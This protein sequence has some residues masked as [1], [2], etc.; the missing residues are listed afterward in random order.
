MTHTIRNRD[1]STPV[2]AEQLKGIKFPHVKTQ[3]EI[4]ELE[5]LNIQKGIDW[6]HRQKGKEYL[7]SAFLCK[8]HKKLFGDVWKWAGTYRKVDVNLS[9]I[10]P[11]Q[12]PMDLEEFFRDMQAWMD[13]G[14]K[15]IKWDEFFAEF[16]HR[17]VSIHPFPNGNGRT[18]RLMTEHLQ[19]MNRKKICSWKASLKN[20]PDKRRN[21]YIIALKKADNHDFQLLVEF[22]KETRD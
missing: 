4:D 13:T 16:H 3:G 9:K 8:L 2:D 17:L 10:T 20:Q 21:D 22:M 6:L 11:F 14:N 18:T 5:D 12:I 1:G 19:R 7:T 15:N